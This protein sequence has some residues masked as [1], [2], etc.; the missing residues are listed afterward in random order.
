GQL[1]GAVNVPISGDTLDLRVA[2]EIERRDGYTKDISF[3]IRT[4]NIDNEGIRAGLTWRPT[5][6]LQNYLVFDGRWDRTHGT[7]NELT[8]I[9]TNPAQLAAFQ[10]LAENTFIANGG[11]AAQGDAAFFAYIGALN[12][13]LGVQ[14]ALG[15]RT[16][17][18]TIEPRFRRDDWGVTD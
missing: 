5:G 12:F 11:T 8:A 17:T 13:A 2:G 6:Y 4:D 15:P 16:I 1:Q 3:G 14:D 18:S 10:T 9:S 7:G